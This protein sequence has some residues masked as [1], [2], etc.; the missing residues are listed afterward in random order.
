MS[1]VLVIGI[2]AWL[3]FTSRTNKTMEKFNAD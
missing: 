1:L 2:K 3:L